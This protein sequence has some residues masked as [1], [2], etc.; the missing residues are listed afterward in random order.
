MM[1]LLQKLLNEKYAKSV[2]SLMRFVC[3]FVIAFYVFCLVLGFMGRVSFTLHTNSAGGTY[4]QAI[5]AEE[6]HTPH[7]RGFTVHMNDDINVWTNAEDRLDL[8]I[9]IG[10]ALMYAV[11]I[12]PLILATWLLSRVFGNVSEGQIFV[13]QNADYLLYYGLILF[14]TALF[15]PFIKLLIC[16]LSNLFSSG[17]MVIST[18]ADILNFLIPSL[19]FMVAAYIIHHGIYLQDEVDHTI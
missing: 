8:P 13:T 14:F 5:C 4:E 16:Q 1:R 2:S 6:S 7:D 15:V 19:A 18:G 10:L 9:K 17:H 12:I 11:N 3:Y